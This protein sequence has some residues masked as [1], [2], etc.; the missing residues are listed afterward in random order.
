[1]EYA[2]NILSFSAS[3][4]LLLSANAKEPEQKEAKRQTPVKDQVTKISQKVRTYAPVSP[5]SRERLTKEIAKQKADASFMDEQGQESITVVTKSLQKLSEHKSKELTDSQKELIESLINALKHTRHFELPQETKQVLTQNIQQRYPQYI[6]NFDNAHTVN[7]I[8]HE[9]YS[10]T[11]DPYFSITVDY[12]NK[13][14][15]A[16]VMFQLQEVQDYTCFRV[17]SFHKEG[18]TQAVQNTIKLSQKEKK[19]TQQ[20]QPII[21]LRDNLGG[22]ASEYQA[23]LDI[24][25]T[26]G[27]IQNDKHEGIVEAKDDIGEKDE[28]PLNGPLLVLINEKSAS[29][30]DRTAYFMKHNKI[31]ILVGERTYGKWT[32]CLNQDLR[33]QPFALPL[34]PS[35]KTFIKKENITIHPPKIQSIRINWSI[36]HQIGQKEWQG[37]KPD[38]YVDWEKVSDEKA[39]FSALSLLVKKGQIETFQKTKQIPTNIALSEKQKKALEEIQKHK[40]E[41]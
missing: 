5:V 28:I 11:H 38:I 40:E 2:R 30:S 4:A 32:K 24:F 39:L 15:E 16:E 37:I 10:K 12:K 25:L 13:L 35:I 19:E 26:T 8:E 14:P 23:F 41:S 27:P 20:K 21:D 34:P 33:I 29:A 6:L 3:I 31:G 22:F 7:A 18:L 17:P 1:M 36:D 9:V